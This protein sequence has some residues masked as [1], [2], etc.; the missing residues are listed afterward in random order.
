[1]PVKTHLSRLFK[2]GKLTSVQVDHGDRVNEDFDLDMYLES[3]NVE[4]DDVEKDDDPEGN[5]EDKEDD[6]KNGE[7]EKTDKEEN[8][9]EEEDVD[10]DS[11]ADKRNWEA[12]AKEGV[13]R[14][15]LVI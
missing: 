12:K 6:S 9:S 14:V 11:D 4:K 15:S 2:H 5:E 7:D 3:L 10:G 8:N 13:R 1:M